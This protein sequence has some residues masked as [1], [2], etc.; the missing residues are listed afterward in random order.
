[1]SEAGKNSDNEASSGK[2]TSGNSERSWMI[3][4]GR[5]SQIGFA[6]PAATGIGWLLGTLLDRFLGTSWLYLVGLLCG[7]AAG[8]IELLRVARKSGRA[9]DAK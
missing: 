7:I 5:Y 8:F 1:M 6:L 9:G 3:Q 2:G 4:L